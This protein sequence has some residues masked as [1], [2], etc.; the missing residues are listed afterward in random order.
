MTYFGFPNGK[1]NSGNTN[2]KYT[3]QEWPK[4]PKMGKIAQIVKNCEILKNGQK[5]LFLGPQYQHLVY[6]F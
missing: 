6:I 1:H 3:E 5:W 4:W 2:S